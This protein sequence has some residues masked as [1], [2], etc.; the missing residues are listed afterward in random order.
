MEKRWIYTPEAITLVESIVS[1]T[2]DYAASH[3]GFVPSTSNG[4]L[5]GSSSADVKLRCWDLMIRKHD[6]SALLTLSRNS[7]SIGKS[8]D[9]RGW[10]CRCWCSIEFLVRWG[11]IL[12]ERSTRHCID[13]LHF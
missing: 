6:D 3:D 10:E 2:W 7:E 1:C 11:N 9:S 4:S 5:R 13:S 8:F 12:A